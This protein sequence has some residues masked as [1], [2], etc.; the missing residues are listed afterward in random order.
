MGEDEEGAGDKAVGG[1]A[2]T[3]DG[4]KDPEIWWEVS[5][6]GLGGGVVDQGLESQQA[7][8]GVDLDQLVMGGL[9]L[10]GLDGDGDA[11]RD[12]EPVGRS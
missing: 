11:S 6:G 7:R 1:V 3:A 8:K 12:E 4:T 5:R 2:E 10:E 9:P